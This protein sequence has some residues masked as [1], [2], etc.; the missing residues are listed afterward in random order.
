MCFFFFFFALSFSFLFFSLLSGILASPQMRWA[1]TET[2]DVP[3]AMGLK[4]A[5]SSRS[6]SRLLSSRP[7]TLKTAKSPAQRRKEL[8][9]QL[10]LKKSLP[11]LMSP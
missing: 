2:K 7:N 4:T 10:L 3:C 1:Q 11:S 5:A 9:Q 6:D 8:S